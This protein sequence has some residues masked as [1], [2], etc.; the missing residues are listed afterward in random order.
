M[1][2]PR[3]LPL[4][5]LAVLAC[6]GAAAGSVTASLRHDAASRAVPVAAPAQPNPAGVLRT[7]YLVDPPLIDA[8]K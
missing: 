6:A 2:L 5:A 3:A 8:V 4:A 1:A 7:E